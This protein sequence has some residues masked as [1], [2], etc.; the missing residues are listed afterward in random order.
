LA[1]LVAADP[2]VG[3]EARKRPDLA[4]VRDT[5]GHESIATTSRYLHALALPPGAVT[6]GQI[7]RTNQISVERVRQ[8]E[9]RAF[10][11]VAGAAT[12]PGTPSAQ[13]A[14]LLRATIAPERPNAL[15]RIDRIAT[16]LF[17]TGWR[18]ASG[19]PWHDWPALRI[20]SSGFAATATGPRA[21]TADEPGSRDG[22]DWHGRPHVEGRRVS[23]CG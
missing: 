3:D 7:A 20:C 18:A 12:T 8:L 13:F 19:Q 15:D 1:V 2:I 16:A 14:A 17:P 5:L 22:S 10:D 4:T 9:Q 21:M 6:Y 11:A 23:A